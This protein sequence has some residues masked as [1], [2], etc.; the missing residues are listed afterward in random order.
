MT[1]SLR[2]CERISWYRV[3][4]WR[5]RACTKCIWRS[6]AEPPAFPRRWGLG[7]RTL[8]TFWFEWPP[9]RKA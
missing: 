2:R 4:G 8:R 6:S 9:F 7:G 3:Q 5:R 1:F